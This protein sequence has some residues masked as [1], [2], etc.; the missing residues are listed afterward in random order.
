M[1]G[2]GRSVLL[3]ES[4]RA[5]FSLLVEQFLKFEKFSPLV[6]TLCSLLMDLVG[7]SPCVSSIFAPTSHKKTKNKVC[8]CCCNIL[9]MHGWVICKKSTTNKQILTSLLVLGGIF[10]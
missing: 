10:T 8:G 4:Q 7:H 2:G 5:A 9:E 3:T 6:V 1:T